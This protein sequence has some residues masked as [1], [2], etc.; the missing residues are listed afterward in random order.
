MKWPRIASSLKEKTT[1]DTTRQDPE[2]A[3]ANGSAAITLGVS[4]LI[5]DNAQS[6]DPV[7]QVFEDGL[8]VD[9][10]DERNSWIYD[11]ERSESGRGKDPSFL[12]ANQLKRSGRSTA[13]F[14]NSLPDTSPEEVQENEDQNRKGISY[15]MGI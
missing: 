3:A 6:P 7:P 4:V 5:L 13:G 15:L 10:T 12:I 1:I 11:N 2:G 14:D 9:D 8:G